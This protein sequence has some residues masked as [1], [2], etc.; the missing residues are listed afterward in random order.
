[1]EIDSEI[2]AAIISVCG[3]FFTAVV[4]IL[5][6]VFTRKYDYHRLF[7]ET[8]S[9]SRNKWLNEMRQYLSAMLAVDNKCRNCHKSSE[10][11]KARNEVVLRLNMEEADHIMLMSQIRIM[12]N[13]TE[14]NFEQTRE[15]IIEIAH[16]IL[17]DE[18][19]KVKE[20][21]KGK[22]DK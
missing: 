1:M 19:E 21:S 5:I 9:Q 10:Y 14:A 8:V 6:Y 22:G 12:D 4:T 11:W 15:N 16:K 7:A 20:E 2:T 17:K 3:V 13:C 18:W